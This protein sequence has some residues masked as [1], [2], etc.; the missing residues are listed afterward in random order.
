IE[1]QLTHAVE[2]FYTEIAVAFQPLAAFCL[3]RR[4]DYEPLLQRGEEFQRRLDT[5]ASRLR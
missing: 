5:L 3:T 1:Q 4:R 2:L